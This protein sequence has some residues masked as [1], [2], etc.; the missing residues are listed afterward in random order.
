MQAE[1]RQ[2]RDT[3]LDQ[4]PGFESVARGQKDHSSNDISA[5]ESHD[6]CKVRLEV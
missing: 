4:E 5:A 3:V 2:G 6:W 1:Q